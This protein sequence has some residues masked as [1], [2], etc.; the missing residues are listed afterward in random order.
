MTRRAVALFVCLWVATACG[1]GPD[2]T[3]ASL[4]SD[5]PAGASEAHPSSAGESAV[6]V[7]GREAS[8]ASDAAAGTGAAQVD[9]GGADAEPPAVGS[10]RASLG[11]TPLP[12]ALRK[13]LRV[14]C[15]GCHASQPG[16]L[17]PMA[18]T[19]VEDL[20]APA[21]S[22]AGRR[23]FEVAA[24]RIHSGVAP[25]PPAESRRLTD[26]E[27]AVLDRYFNADL[28]AG[29]SDCEDSGGLM[30][31]YPAPE[32][33]EIDQCYR[34][35]AHD[36]AA[37]GDLTPYTPPEGESYA[38]FFFAV[39][40]DGPA[41]AL[42][43]RSLHSPL[44]HHWLLSDTSYGDRDGELM[45]N[46]A[47]CGF[48]AET[49]LAVYGVNQQPVLNMPPDVGLQLP[50]KDSGR[51]LLL[52]VH[53]YNPQGVEADDTG[54]EICTARTPRAE[55]A[56]VLGLGPL[57]FTLPAGTKTDVTSTCTP[58]YKGDIHILRSFPHMHARGQA[59]D[60]IIERGDGTHETLI[61]VAF[62][63]NNQ[64]AYDTQATLRPGDSLVTTCHFFND[65]NS[66]IYIGDR[67]SDEMCI[68]FVTAWPASALVTGKDF[69]GA[70]VCAD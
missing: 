53:Y 68:N 1:G 58:T 60:T 65:T 15:Q 3:G 37:P 29:P 67:T 20:Q 14:S 36:V 34:F 33:E 64:I 51:G 26:G 28:A 45:R 61:D 32:P 4:A 18:L 6:V 48:G 13:V 27:L 5:D 46:V 22:D 23:V 44:T 57:W 16:M 47:N 56:S 24:E 54:V 38:C 7:A 66:R 62:D 30:T 11:D 17:A 42:S 19:S 43:F 39:P 69:S 41:Q 63:F 70:E 52:G 10:G 31:G 40:W 2:R 35:Q 50:T 12:C 59:L 21:P 49:V 9:A 25:M 55:T 8:G